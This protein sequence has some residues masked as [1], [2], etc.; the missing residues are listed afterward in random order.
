M[1]KEQ[2]LPRVKFQFPDIVS[3]V[4]LSKDTYINVSS[5]EFYKLKNVINLVDDEGKCEK[6]RFVT[7]DSECFLLV[8]EKCVPRIDAPETKEAIKKLKGMVMKKPSTK[9]TKAKRSKK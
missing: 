2:E 8:P 3:K 4:Y 1:A 6:Y 7:L 9:S 5:K